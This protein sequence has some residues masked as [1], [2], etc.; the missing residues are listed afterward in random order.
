MIPPTEE[1]FIYAP[2]RAWEKMTGEKKENV[3]EEEARALYSRITSKEKLPFVRVLS[4]L[5]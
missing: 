1:D 3:T 5:M 2:E 4:E